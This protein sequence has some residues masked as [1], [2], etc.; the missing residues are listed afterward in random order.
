[1]E[2]DTRDTGRKIFSEAGVPVRPNKKFTAFAW[3]VPIAFCLVRVLHAVRYGRRSER[4]GR[5]PRN[6]DQAGSLFPCI[7]RIHR[8]AQTGRQEDAVV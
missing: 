2:L 1:M 6:R 7:Q 3:P 5:S 4:A 8:G